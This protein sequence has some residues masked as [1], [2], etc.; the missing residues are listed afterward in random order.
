MQL[1]VRRREGVADDAPV[2]SSSSTNDP[3]EK[4]MFRLG[5]LR[6]LLVGVRVAAANAADADRQGRL[7]KSKSRSGCDLTRATPPA[8]S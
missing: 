4:V 8:R 5:P 7:L 1:W 3:T 2:G 6:L